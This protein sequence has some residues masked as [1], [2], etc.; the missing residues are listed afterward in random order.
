MLPKLFSI[1]IVNNI[2]RC[3]NR[4][5]E[6]S[7][8]KYDIFGF[9]SGDSSDCGL[10]NCETL[11]SCMCLPVFSGMFQIYS[12]DES[13]VFFQNIGYS[14]QKHIAS[15]SIRPQCKLIL[16]PTHPLFS[17]FYSNVLYFLLL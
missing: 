4:C 14:V 11:A 17:H 10:L 2:Q 13:S 9:H 3:H 12:E 7:L 1:S 8:F 15:Q 5:L 16:R 6:N